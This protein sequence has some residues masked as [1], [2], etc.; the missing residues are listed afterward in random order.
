VKIKTQN[1]DA[2]AKESLNSL[3]SIIIS[4]IETQNITS[5]I[6]LPENKIPEKKIIRR[7][8]EIRN[9]CLSSFF[10]ITGI[11]MRGKTKNFF[12]YLPAIYSFLRTPAN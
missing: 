5:G 12:F 11:R 10:Q 9:F 4:N 1:K 8:V 2:I 7:T 6:R 3:I